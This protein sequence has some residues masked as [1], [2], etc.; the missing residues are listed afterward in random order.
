M[1]YFLL[2]VSMLK[3]LSNFCLDTFNVEQ[4]IYFITYFNL[5]RSWFSFKR[6]LKLTYNFNNL[7][8]YFTWLWQHLLPSLKITFLLRIQL[9]LN[10]QFSKTMYKMQSKET[11]KKLSQN[12]SLLLK[13]RWAHFYWFMFFIL[14]LHR[15][16]KHLDSLLKFYCIPI[17]NVPVLTD[18]FIKICQNLSKE[19]YCLIFLYIILHFFLS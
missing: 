19:I 7:I 10:I 11:I 14:K 5:M 6:I 4:N 9:Y 1:V 12:K 16:Y 17:N 13:I 2:Y 3:I 18:Y 8:L 15:G